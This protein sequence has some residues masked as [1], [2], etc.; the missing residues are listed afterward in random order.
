[1]MGSIKPVRD[2]GSKRPA[3]DD[4]SMVMLPLPKALAAR[5]LNADRVTSLAWQVTRITPPLVRPATNHAHDT[6]CGETR[7]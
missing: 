5:L 4:G 1:M 7:R 6:S 2:A 3:K